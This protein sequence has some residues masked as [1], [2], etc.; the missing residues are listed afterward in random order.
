MPMP[1]VGCANKFEACRCPN[2]QTSSKE[3][4]LQP[5][6]VD[7]SKGQVIQPVNVRD[8]SPVVPFQDLLHAPVALNTVSAI[9]ASTKE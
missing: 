5:H 2:C 1:F 6:F 9:Q 8:L 4:H 7:V 3:T